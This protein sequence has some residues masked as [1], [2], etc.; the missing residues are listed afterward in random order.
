MGFDD[1]ARWDGEELVIRHDRTT[2]AWIYI[3]IHSTHRGPAVGGTRIRRYPDLDDA[4]QD[5]L[6][7]SSGMTAKNALADMP[8]GGA[9]AVL[10]VREIPGGPERTGLLTRYGSLV[11][12]L[13]G[14]FITGPDMGTTED[15]MNVIGEVTDNVFCRS[16][17]R[18]G[19]G[20]ASPG[21]AA[22][23]LH[24]IR[25][26]LAHR[27]GSGDLRGRS[28][29]VQGLGE[30]G[31]RLVELLHD[32]GADLMV[33][34]VDAARV[35][36]VVRRHDDIRAVDSAHALETACDLFS[37]CAIGSVLSKETIGRLRCQVVCGAANNQLA[38]P[39]DG[40]R[41]RAADI[42]YAP[43]YAANAG[44]IIYGLGLE[45]FHWDAD[46]VNA[47]LAGI[48]D[49]LTRIFVEAERDGVATNLVADR[50]AAESLLRP[51]ELVLAAR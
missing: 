11:D 39:E 28:I 3:A 33:T 9:K 48:A 36:D 25:A 38:E 8:I 21:T 46:Q 7:L 41:L 17:G 24:A 42:L 37:P 4:A 44:G 35:A 12:S 31:G 23:M 2:D 5:A 45:R 6:R 18:G 32:A 29:L 13:D 51:S 26:S 14:Q 49:T 20:T 10:A 47:R 27:F 22:G 16:I 1:L 34:D 30:V 40:E 43:D 50:M 15:D 19:A